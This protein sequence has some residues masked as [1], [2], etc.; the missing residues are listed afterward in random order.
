MLIYL[1]AQC[2][3]ECTICGTSEHTH[4]HNTSI[5]FSLK[6]TFTFAVDVAVDVVVVVVS[7]DARIYKRA[8]SI[9]KINE[10]KWRVVGSHGGFAQPPPPGWPIRRQSLYLY[11]SVSAGYN[12]KM[13]GAH[14]RHS[15]ARLIVYMHKLF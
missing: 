7:G 15:L 6:S 2:S 8:K 13:C 9:Y 1:N 3:G 14:T 11:L 12:C 5:E 10:H 4:A